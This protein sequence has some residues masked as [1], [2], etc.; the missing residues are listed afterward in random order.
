MVV[1]VVGADGGR[2]MGADMDPLV[3]DAAGV[4]VVLGAR[5]R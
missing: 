1:D 5:I 4:D 2:I 3:V